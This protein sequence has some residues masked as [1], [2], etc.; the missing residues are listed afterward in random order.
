MRRD[1]LPPHK[2][3]TYVMPRHKAV[4]VWVNK[5]ACTSI[6]WLVAG[7][8]EESA[9]RFHGSLSREVSRTMT[10]HRRPLWQHTPTAASLPEEQLAEIS[11]DNGWFVFAVVR[12]PLA[13]MF[14]AWQSKL[15]L[16]EPAW[17]Q[18][19]G[20]R[21]WFPRVP[22]TSEELLDDWLGFARTMI[23]EPDPAI[24]RNRHFAPQR[25]LL[26]PD[27]MPYTRIYETREI[28]QLLEDFERHLRAQ[29][30]DGDPLEL[31]RANETPLRPL[32]AVFPP[33]VLEGLAG[34][35]REDFETF[36]FG[37]PL[38]RGLDAADRYPDSAL[39]EIERLVERAER[40]NDLALQARTFKREAERAAKVQAAAA[41]NGGE[42]PGRMR[43]L[44]R[45]LVTRR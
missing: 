35:Y 2:T 17:A 21:P 3:A 37:D 5:A 10:I 39:Q 1:Q 40:I 41:A 14:S 20:D 11:P 25:V 29:G 38:P 13:R 24:M 31:M 32:A 7:L 12:Q 43:A 42:P 15:L 22:R 34:I 44:A 19:F 36:N 33:D 4:Y 26:A 23:A 8:Q 30:W 18:R 9:E 27:R 45:R 16:R 6:K 28:P